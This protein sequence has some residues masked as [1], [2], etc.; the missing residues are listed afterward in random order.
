M[1]ACRSTLP[2]LDQRLSP[3]LT[4]SFRDVTLYA[5]KWSVLVVVLRIDVGHGLW[6]SQKHSAFKSFNLPE[7]H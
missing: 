7:M 1:T 2:M 6:Y 3:L 4:T 5:T